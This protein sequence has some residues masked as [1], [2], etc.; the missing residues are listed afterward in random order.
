MRFLVTIYISLFLSLSAFA[1]LGLAGI[2]VLDGGR[3]KPFDSFARETLQLTF[4]RET[5]NKRPAKFI[6]FSWLLVPDEWD[7]IQFIQVRHS[8]LRESLGLDKIRTHYSPREL[9]TNDKITVL[10]QELRSKQQNKDKLNPFYQAVQ[11]LEAQVSSYNA[12]RSGLMPRILPQK[13]QSEWLPVARLPEEHQNRFKEITAAFLTFTKAEAS[14]EAQ[15]PALE[16]LNAKADSFVAAIE[17]EHKDNYA[18]FSKIKAELMFFKIHPFMY[19]WVLYLLATIFFAVHFS[20]GRRMFSAL[21]WVFVSL[22]FFLHSYGFFLR[23]YVTD[24]PPVSNMYETVIWVAWG[25][26]LIAG[27]LYK[28]FNQKILMPAATL[29][30]MF[31]L[32]LSDLS[33]QVLDKTMQPL[34]AVLRDNFWLV[35]HVLTITLSYAGFFVA[36]VIGVIALFWFLQDEQ[37]NT[38]KIGQASTAM[39]RLIQVGVVLLAGGIILG[40]IWADYSWGR[41]WGWDP[42]ETWAL[43]ALLGYL[44]ILHGRLIGWIKNFALSVTCILG[45]SLVIMAWYGVNFV[46]GAGLH[47]YGFGA[48]GVEYVAAFVALQI[49]YVAF[50]STVRHSRKKNSG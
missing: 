7:D 23:V 6:V 37:K 33:P 47:T 4:G 19:A 2:P 46:L 27:V 1:D 29:T 40:G 20:S 43:I 30:A 28:F 45:F 36:M 21:S 10:I 24:R 11:T 35:T 48:G 5:F 13:D 17:Q 15:A 14:S 9:M 31:C 42:K 3:V 8:G 26:V 38:E 25:S 32:I 18:D 49:L 34:E 44:A 16:N 39:Y 50:V 41:F 22:G 12:I